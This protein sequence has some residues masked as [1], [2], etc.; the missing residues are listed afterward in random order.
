MNSL[1]YSHIVFIT[2]GYV[3]QLLWWSEGNTGAVFFGFP[4]TRIMTQMY[5]FSLYCIQSQAFFYS[6]TEQTIPMPFLRTKVG[7]C[8]NFIY[9]LIS[10]HLLIQCLPARNS[11]LPCIHLYPAYHRKIADFCSFHV[12]PHGSF[13]QSTSYHNAHLPLMTPCLYFAQQWY[14]YILC[15]SIW[16]SCLI[17]PLWTSSS[18]PLGYD[19]VR[20][21]A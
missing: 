11:S 20:F 19:V 12:F 21:W 9:P 17:P 10:M 18:F 3:S 4:A 8:T 14:F 6:N 5:L 1:L 7:F 15:Y 2:C 13:Y 16:R